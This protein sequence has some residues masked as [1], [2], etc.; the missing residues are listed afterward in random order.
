MGY[1]TKFEGE[2]KFTTDLTAKQLAKVKSFLDE[3]WRDHPEW[4]CPDPK[5]H[6]SYIDL[7]LLDDF[8]GLEWNGAEKTSGMVE[9]VNLIITEMRKDYSE[10]GLEGTFLAKGE[11]AEDRWTLYIGTDGLA[12]RADI[13]VVGQKIK[14]PHCKRTFIV[15]GETK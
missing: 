3:D 10:F 14:C 8:T 12:H 4:E 7:K 5:A 13:P 11:D 1:S 9:S 15:E 6:V 2:L